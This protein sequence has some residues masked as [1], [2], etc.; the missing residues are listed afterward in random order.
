MNLFIPESQVARLLG[1]RLGEWLQLAALYERK[2]FPKTDIL[3]GGRYE[4][5]IRAFFDREYGLTAG[6]PKRPDGLEDATTWKTS[7]R[8]EDPTTGS[9]RRGQS[10]K[11]SPPKPLD[12]REIYR[13]M[14]KS[15]PD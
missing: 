1:V 14:N 7:E 3:M 8:S 4:P 15:P 6:P 5:A 9:P 11:G 13:G 2:G 12:L 10:K